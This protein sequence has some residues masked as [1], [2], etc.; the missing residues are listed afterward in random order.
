M[1]KDMNTMRWRW[2]FHLLS[3]DA[4]IKLVLTVLWPVFEFGYSFIIM[5]LFWF[6]SADIATVPVRVATVS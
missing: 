4:P 1:L 6:Y 5:N 2:I 3:A